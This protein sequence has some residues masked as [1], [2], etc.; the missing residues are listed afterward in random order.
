VDLCWRRRQIVHP[1]VSE[2]TTK[3]YGITHQKRQYS[4]FSPLWEPWIHIHLRYSQFRYYWRFVNATWLQ[5]DWWMR[6]RFCIT[7]TFA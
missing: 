7:R 6:E 3:T 2:V 5:H 4:S 1:N